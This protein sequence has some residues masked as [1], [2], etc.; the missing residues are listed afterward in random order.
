MR[1]VPVTAVELF[2]LSA[3]FCPVGGCEAVI[4]YAIGDRQHVLL[5]RSGMPK[6]ILR[7]APSK[8]VA[9]LGV[10]SVSSVPD[11]PPRGRLMGRKRRSGSDGL[12][13]GYIRRV[14]SPSPHIDKFAGDRSRRRH[15]W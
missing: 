2:T 12:S 4:T 15:R 7:A 13:R 1:A 8:K 10:G 14:L 9:W 3:A 5:R 6:A 11:L